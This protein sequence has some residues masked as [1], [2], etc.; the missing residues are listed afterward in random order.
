M[1]KQTAEELVKE[2][3]EFIQELLWDYEFPVEYNGTLRL[4]FQ[5]G[6]VTI[7]EE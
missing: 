6:V 2:I 7:S 3:V 5:D 4:K 1:K